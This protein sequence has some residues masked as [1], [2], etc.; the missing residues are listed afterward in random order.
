[1]MHSCGLVLFTLFLPAAA[2]RSIRSAD[3][4]HDTQQQTND[5]IQAH[6]GSAVARGAFLPQGF[7]RVLHAAHGQRPRLHG[8]DASRG[9]S[10]AA[11]ALS[12]A[13]DPVEEQQRSGTVEMKGSQPPEELDEYFDN[14]EV[15]VFS[16]SLGSRLQPRSVDELARVADQ[17]ISQSHSE[18]LEQPSLARSVQETL[19]M[20]SLM[21]WGKRLP[22]QGAREPLGSTM[23]EKD[24]V[25]ELLVLLRGPQTP[26]LRMGDY[27]IGIVRHDPTPYMTGSLSWLVGHIQIKGFKRYL[28]F[29]RDA[30]V[31]SDTAGK[32]TIWDD[33]KVNKFNELITEE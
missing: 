6:E 18:L 4:F 22:V 26:G 19:S 25:N 8:E 2:G 3:A 13:P 1:M 16:G 12:A 23:Y 31:S 10:R 15:L 29:A 24:K 21:P 11:V 17:C 30:D 28:L 9:Q 5:H 20:T 7:W 33:S 32:G 27:W 14:L